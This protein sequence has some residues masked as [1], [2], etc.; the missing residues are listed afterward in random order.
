M[1]AHKA[2]A[3]DSG[4]LTPGI[5]QCPGP[6]FDLRVM[7]GDEPQAAG[8]MLHAARP[9]KGALRL[10]DIDDNAGAQPPHRKRAARTRRQR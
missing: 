4:N 6:R 10:R 7:V 8:V 3:P 5:S 1:T 9:C 2:G